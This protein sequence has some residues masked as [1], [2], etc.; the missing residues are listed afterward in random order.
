MP[1]KTTIQTTGVALK[2]LKDEEVF[3]EMYKLYYS[4]LYS[5][6][7]AYVSSNEDAEEIVQDVFVKFWKKREQIEILSNLTGY[8]YKMT[9]NSC[10]DFL[11]SQKNK[12]AIGT[13]LHQQQ[14]LLNYFALSSEADSLIIEKELQFQINEGIKLLPEK[15]RMVFMKSRMEGLKY[16]EISN[17]MDISTK[18]VENQI[19]KALKHLRSHLKEHFSLF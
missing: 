14:Y 17:S 11:R 2:Q 19:S 7:L 15:C 12:L 5:I 16:R 6:A 9:R 10:L 4:K 3:D 1:I 18:T 8:L 13:N